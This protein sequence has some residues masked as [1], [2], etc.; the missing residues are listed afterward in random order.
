[1]IEVFTAP[2]TEQYSIELQVLGE[3]RIDALR[4]IE[5]GPTTQTYFAP[6]G[7]VQFTIDERG[8]RTEYTL[9]LLGR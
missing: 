4:V 6:T 8:N 3:A 7:E 5:V 9:D 2:E 1:M